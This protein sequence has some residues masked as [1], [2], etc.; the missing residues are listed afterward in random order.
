MSIK[1]MSGV[2]DSTDLAPTEKL[3]MLS[4]ADHA[5]DEGRCYPSIGRLCLRTGLKERAIQTNLKRLAEKG[6][7]KIVPN[8]GQG[9]ANLY[10][11]SAKAGTFGGEDPRTKCT[12]HEMHPAYDDIDPPHMTTQPPAGDAPK[13]SGSIKEPSNNKRDLVRILSQVLDEKT[14]AAFVAHR[15]AKKA[16]LTSHAADLVVK[17]LTGHRD[18]DSVINKSILNGWSGIFP[19]G[20]PSQS[21][22]ATQFPRIRAQLPKEG[23]L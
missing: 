18:P 16:P 20:Q 7:L 13:P 8:A 22:P 10:F 2:F 17:M 23:M 11:V 5:N 15:K 19:D 9:G 1:V 4:L 12:P 21:Q 3:I 14:A 6:Y